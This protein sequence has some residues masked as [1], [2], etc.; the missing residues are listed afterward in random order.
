MSGS[1]IPNGK[2]QYLD[3]N[4]APLAG[5]KV[6]YYIPYTTMAK[7][8]WQDINLT[9]LNT[10][11]II[12][13]SA[14]ECIA[15]GSGAYRQ[16]VYDVNDNLIWDQYTYGI[17]PAGSNFI[18]Q[19]EV[20]TAT[21]GQTVFTLATIT[22]VPGIN[23]LVVFV[24]GSKQVTGTNYTETA[25][26]TVTFVTGLN[27]G[28]VI[29][30]YASL[31][32]S[33]QN[34]SNAVNVA[35][36]PPFPA[37]ATTNVQ[38]KLAQTVSVKDFGAVGDGTTDDTTA[39]QTALNFS[40]NI[41]IP[42]GTYKITSSLTFGDNTNIIFAKNAKLI[43]G[44]NNL[45]MFLVSSHAYYSQIRN[46]T[47]D[48]NGYTNIIGFDLTNFRLQSGLY[49]CFVNN[50]QY[51]VIVKSCFG[52]EI[53]NFGSFTTPNPIRILN[54]NSGINIFNPNLDNETGGSGIGNG[55]YVD[56]GTVT[57]GSNIG[58]IIQNGFIQGFN[59]GVL[60]QSLATKIENTYF[61]GCVTADIFCNSAIDSIISGTTH[62][63]VVG[64]VAIKAKNSD[65]ISVLLP[66]MGSG[67]RTQL[68]DFDTS[69]TNCVYFLDGSISSINYPIGIVTG[70][71]SLPIQI[72]GTFT[73]TIVGTAT[74]GT[75]TYTVRNGTYCKIGNMVNFA[76]SI[77]WTAHTG[78]GSI[79]ITGLPATLAPPNI[80]Y[81]SNFPTSPVFAFT[82]PIVFTQLNG[83][84]TNMTCVQVSTSGMASYI[85]L[86]SSGT[87]N[88]SG[89]YNITAG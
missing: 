8:T 33:A 32:A 17:S 41:Y 61:E 66:T 45:T 40:G 29:D 86:P 35:Y 73:P 37:S 9:I 80:N 27:A 82:G 71:N 24:N 83:V 14:G 75:G 54:N 65:A 39:I 18:S 70:I 16:Q 78:T 38:A 2:Q 63:G 43:A 31:P 36:V 21:Q 15:W 87:L 19:E 77:T 67:A 28:D 5:G 51:G 62:Y 48:G 7:N 85:P 89:S 88:I 57:S 1:L 13:D 42:S 30:F 53:F 76:M 69:N 59:Y 50:M 10:N 3:A 44:V 84:S 74:A 72:N 47:L 25:G 55:V 58:V 52:A 26:N 6:Y 79:S 20:Q 46:A 23:S 81:G 49:D 56:T 4:G 11:P 68:L 64:A 22:Y 60:D 12:L 34:M